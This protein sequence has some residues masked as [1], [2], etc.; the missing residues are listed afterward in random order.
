MFAF[1]LHP[2]CTDYSV[3]QLPTGRPTRAGNTPPP[4]TKEYS[5]MI[6][7]PVSSCHFKLFAPYLPQSNR[8][9]IGVLAAASL[10][11]NID[12]YPAMEPGDLIEVFWGDCYVAS[13]LLAQADI[14][15]TTV[16]HIPES[17][18][19]SGKIKTYYRV[20]KIGSEPVKSPPCKLWVK[21][22]PPGGHL[23]CAGNDENQGLA[24]V[25]F[26]SHVLD[27]GL[28]EK[29]LNAGVDVTIECYPNMDTYDEITLRWG[30]V[31]LDLPALTREQVGKPVTIRVP[32]AMIREAGDDPH[33]EVT[34]CVIDRVGNNS[35]W[36]PARSIRVCTSDD[37]QFV[38]V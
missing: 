8:H 32:E 23:L 4:Y 9:G 10:V 25:T 6:H 7:T 16:L 1:N 21:L 31:R 27:Q 22:E 34:Y 5:N 38:E 13:A 15:Y 3:L 28:S 36:A 20:T 26:A 11:V 29:Q 35:L 24:P 2:A 17:F 18:L 12:P 19:Q 14:G 37:A 33:Q 30:D